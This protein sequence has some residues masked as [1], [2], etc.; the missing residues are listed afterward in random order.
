[1]SSGGIIGIVIVCVVAVV[2]IGLIAWWIGSK[3]TIARMEVKIEE[4]LSGIDVALEKRFDL[5]TKMFDITKGYAKHEK[6]TLA[7]VIGMRTDKLPS[8]MSSKDMQDL[9]AKL[10]SAANNINL[11]AEQYPELKANTVFIELQKASRDAE[12]HLQA[13]R[14][15]YN[16]NVSAY[17]Q[18][19]RV[20]PSSIPARSLGCQEKEFFEVE[21]GKREDVKMDF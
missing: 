20:W 8:N 2:A 18:Y 1:M 7:Q 11:V 14:R 19:I 21:E 3:N 12:E 5:L 6:E 13:A 4:S 16:S 17:N 15:V 10:T 9:T